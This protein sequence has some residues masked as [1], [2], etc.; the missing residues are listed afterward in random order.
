MENQKKPKTVI[1]KR[2]YYMNILESDSK[3][4]AQLQSKVTSIQENLLKVQGALIL[5]DEMLAEEKE[6][7]QFL[8]IKRKTTEKSTV[9][10]VKNNI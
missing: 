8:E 1:E 4:L 9:K 2:A 7:R 5:L 10:V 3:N 6:E